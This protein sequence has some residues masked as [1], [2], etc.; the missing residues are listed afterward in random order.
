LCGRISI[1]HVFAILLH[2]TIAKNTLIEPLHD[3]LLE[4]LIGED[5]IEKSA[6]AAKDG[7]EYGEQGS[8]QVGWEDFV[9]GEEPKDDNNNE[10]RCGDDD[11]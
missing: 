2:V 7:S 6:E 11:N 10:N 3:R 9:V 5:G 1:F 4:V 8:E